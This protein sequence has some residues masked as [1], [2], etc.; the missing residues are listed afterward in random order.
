MRAQLKHDLRYWTVTGECSEQRDPELQK[1]VYE[2][3]MIEYLVCQEDAV[4]HR[5]ADRILRVN[6]RAEELTRALVKVGLGICKAEQKRLAAFLEPLH[7]AHR[8]W[9]L[10]RYLSGRNVSEDAAG[11][12]GRVIPTTPWG[13]TNNG[14]LNPLCGC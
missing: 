2:D 7:R 3:L 13:L 4:K 10:R 5:D 1:K 8:R 9:V 6:E 14:D 11:I 12:E